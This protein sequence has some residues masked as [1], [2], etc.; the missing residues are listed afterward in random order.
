MIQRV[1]G[2]SVLRLRFLPPKGLFTE[3][4]S[5]GDHFLICFFQLSDMTSP[6][7]Q[8]AVVVGQAEESDEEKEEAAEPNSREELEKEEERKNSRLED[9]RAGLAAGLRLS[10]VTATVERTLGSLPSIE[11]PHWTQP[12]ASSKKSSPGNEGEPQ[13]PSLLHKRLYERNGEVHA[14]LHIFFQVGNYLK[15][16]FQ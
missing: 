8:A 5:D 12:A 3:H 4:C 16:P 1:R 9:A 15:D 2:P 10:S 14:D 6:S 13:H 7:S 11:L